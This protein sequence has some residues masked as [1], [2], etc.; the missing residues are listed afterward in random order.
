MQLF[1]SGCTVA[2][3]IA[4]DP[5]N[6]EIMIQ[7]FAVGRV[8]FYDKRPQAGKF[9]AWSRGLPPPWPLFQ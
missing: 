5:E 6:I 9:M 2:C 4:L 3:A 1:Q 7:H 8:A